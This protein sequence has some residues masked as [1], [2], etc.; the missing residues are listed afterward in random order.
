MKLS[1]I[2]LSLILAVLFVVSSCEDLTEEPIGLLNPE[3]FFASPEDVALGINGGYSLLGHESFMGRK[4]SLSLLLRGD[5]AT[6]GDMATPTRRIEVDQM[7]MSGNNGMVTAFWPMGYEALAALNY[8]IEGGENLDLSDEIINPT[9]AEGRFLRGFINYHFVRLFGEIPKI[10]F[11][12]TDPELAYTLQQS[13]V[14]SVYAS[15]ISDFQYAKQWL[16]DVASM[17]A[18]PGKGTA[19]AFLSSVYLTRENWQAAYDE[20]KFVID[21][22]GRFELQLDPEYANLF[23]PSI[24]SSSNEVLFEVDFLGNDAATNLSSLGGTNAA[25]DYLASVTGIIGDSRFSFG[26]GWSVAVPSL[27]VYENWDSRDYRK[28]V[29]F[30]TVMVFEGEEVLYSE[31]GTIPSAIPRPHIAKY[32]R[33]LGVSGSAASSNG[34]DSDIDYICMRYAEVLLIAAEALNEINGSPTAEAIGYVDQIRS[35]ARR[36]LDADATNDNLFPQNVSGG[37]SVDAF[38]TLVLEER[39]LELSFEGGRWY[40]IAR[41][42]LGTEAFGPS[43]LEP[44]NFNPARD[45]LFPKYQQDVDINPNLSQNDLY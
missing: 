40:D 24:S 15:I 35:R 10:D 28:A 18:R 32:F 14:D 23:D 43:G 6:I 2:K 12:F 25:I 34:R 26:A 13:S 29:S 16:P 7:N 31:W 8:A 17:R 37:L 22:S 11:A 41:R 42:K 3:G 4:L 5:M 39:R 36:E 1:I 9:I 20:A 19:T 45:Y 38:R 33:A 30:D 21:N 44:Q 27:A